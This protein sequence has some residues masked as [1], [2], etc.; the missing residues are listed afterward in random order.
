M[1]GLIFQEV[2]KFYT[3]ED[4]HNL[5]R[6]GASLVNQHHFK[7]DYILAIG[8]GGF[9]P[10]RI[11]RTFIDVPILATTISFYDGDSQTP[12]DTPN[13]IQSIDTDCICGKN[14][15]IVDEVDDTRKTLKALLDTLPSTA[16]YGIFVVHNKEK[17]KVAVIPDNIPYFACET[18]SDVWIEYPWDVCSEYS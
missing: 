9:I 15:L 4:I 11:L 1:P 3:Y 18:T 8:G 14:V 17:E 5:V 10:A 13:I 16:N 12:N 7:P 2:K 6:K